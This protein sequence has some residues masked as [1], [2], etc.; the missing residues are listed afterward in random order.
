MSYS[1]NNSSDISVHITSTNQYSDEH[2][3]AN[4]EVPSDNSKVALH[5]G[6]SSSHNVNPQYNEN[7]L[8]NFPA[9]EKINEKDQT[10]S[11]IN[12]GSH[13]V[14]KNSDAE[15]PS[16]EK[17]AQIFEN[18]INNQNITVE[19][20]AINLNDPNIQQV[21]DG[22]AGNTQNNSQ[23]Q[24]QPAQQNNPAQANAVP[25]N[26]ANPP[27]A[28]PGVQPAA[29]I[30][31]PDQTKDAF[32][33]STTHRQL[34]EVIKALVRDGHQNITIE[35]EFLK[36]PDPTGLSD[37][38]STLDDKF[39]G[40][41]VYEV[42]CRYT[43]KSNNL[44]ANGFP[45]ERPI[46]IYGLA[47]KNEA[48]QVANEYQK[49][50]SGIALMCGDPANHPNAINGITPQDVAGDNNPIMNNS[51]FL[52]NLQR[53]NLGIT[54][55][56]LSFKSGDKTLT[57]QPN[58][59]WYIYN[60]TQPLDGNNPRKVTDPNVVKNEVNNPDINKVIYS[61]NEW[62]KHKKMKLKDE[63]VET[64]SILSRMKA[65]EK[66]VPLGS[67][68]E[69]LERRIEKEQKEF[70]IRQS[71]FTQE[72]RFS[73][74]RGKFNPF[75]KAL[76]SSGNLA[77]FAKSVNEFRTNKEQDF[78]QQQQ[79]G[80]PNQINAKQ[81]ELQLKQQDI[82]NQQNLIARTQQDIQNLDAQ[83]RAVVNPL[84]DPNYAS[85]DSAKQQKE[86]EH[87]QQV[88][89]AN[90]LNGELQQIQQSLTDLQNQVNTVGTELDKKRQGIQDQVNNL[91]FLDSL[92]HLLGERKE[93]LNKLKQEMHLSNP[94]DYGP[95]IGKL[96]EM[97]NKLTNYMEKN[98]AAI[99]LAR[100]S[101]PN[102]IL[103]NQP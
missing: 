54:Q 2:E 5:E 70:E 58:N 95:F 64:L 49:A 62:I 68:I 80:L 44:P 76:V 29:Q 101:L 97:E 92:N 17:M 28:A 1:I 13:R 91:A 39:P 38:V 75:K 26:P 86:T 56:I 40:E 33:T 83:L 15:N 88:A 66:T 63:P 23:A 6:I 87:Q 94:N 77:E 55:S 30:L 96:Q 36:V 31:T 35:T 37:I 51:A 82:Q 84:T 47:G 11:N 27:G 99:D 98:Q 72:I 102:A 71:A 59:V 90:V 14:R 12:I 21:P 41:N 60:P 42:K 79:V 103:G 19:V 67:Q 65:K 10:N 20:E 78:I 32:A 48:M 50:I 16:N 57:I 52:L 8:Q 22:Q 18:S 73:P 61:E 24:P 85:I 43:I 69:E 93:Y 53:D 9:R 34:S 100:G 74:K 25:P 45:V 3:N 46:R 4:L 89:Q 81:Q 7:D